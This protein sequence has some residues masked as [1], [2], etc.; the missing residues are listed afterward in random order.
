[1]RSLLLSLCCCLA[2]GAQ[3][4]GYIGAQAAEQPQ[5]PPGSLSGSVVDAVTGEPVRGASV[6]LLHYGR[7]GMSNLKVD[8]A[9]QFSAA[10]LQPGQYAVQVNHQAYPGP[11]G[12]TP[13]AVM[14]QV[15][16]GK[17]TTGVVIKLPPG[18][19]ISGRIL[20]DDGEPLMNCTLS[21]TTVP[22]GGLPVRQGGFGQTNDEGE[23][24][25][26]SIAPD[27]YLL[28]TRCGEAL[29]VERLLDRTG[30]EGLDPGAGWRPSFYPDSPTRSG[31]TSI[32]V[33]SGANIELELSMKATPVTTVRGVVVTPAGAAAP[34]VYRVLLEP[35]DTATGRNLSLEHS[36]QGKSGRFR[37]TMVPPGTYRVRAIPLG[38]RSQPAWYG[39]RT[40]TVGTTPPPPIRL[41]M[42]PAIRISG[43]VEDPRTEEGATARPAPRMRIG[44]FADLPAPESPKGSISFTEI[45]TRQQSQ[46]IRNAQV[47]AADGTF[48]VEGLTPGRWRVEYRSFRGPAW[49][50]SM[51]YGEAPN[52]GQSIEVAQGGASPLLIQ[53]GGK[54]AELRYE[55]KGAGVASKTTWAIQAIRADGPA[56]MG[57]NVIGS[58]VRG[59]PMLGQP[60]APGRYYIFAVEAMLGG[61]LVNDRVNQLL[62]RELKVVEVAA[63]REQT[64]E[65]PCFTQEEIRQKI[66]AFLADDVR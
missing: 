17:A 61:S 48:E 45:D 54:S 6:Q 22:L 20:S 15:E 52:D 39:S 38:Q 10:D 24:R 40:I 62:L 57:V 53:L 49:I 19:T 2:A 31:A 65:V 8:G 50:E 37:I 25:I 55:L 33:V 35:E 18:G 13:A 3:N 46:E 28:W 43:R 29:P 36:V 9:G 32:A 1:M 60:L 63:G 21:L 16:S 59:Q 56:T 11:L 4:P 14:V 41:Q 47:K 58:I 23:F 44:S 51:Q 7:G 42:E 66:A 27:R 30:P 5:Q 26:A 12:V 34:E 64:I